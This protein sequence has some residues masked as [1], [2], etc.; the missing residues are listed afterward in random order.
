MRRCR[1]RGRVTRWPAST[2][3]RERR[4]FHYWR[5]RIDYQV[6]KLVHVGCVAVSYALFV[7][8]GAW[9]IRES[10]W[11]GRRWVRVV[12]H[13]VD[14]ALLA[15]A[16]AMAMT[17][18]QYPFVVGWLTAKLLALVCYIGLGMVALKR[19]RTRRIRIAAWMAAQAVFFYIVAVA[20]TRN[21]LPWTA[22][23]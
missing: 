8:R 23:W 1:R 15:S 7:L 13:V 11:L 4:E 20:V 6:L 16:V 5:K 10:P 14:T 12:P 9:M 2:C 3:C 17:I 19:G 22:A 21:P 18:R